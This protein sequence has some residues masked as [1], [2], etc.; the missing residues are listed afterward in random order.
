MNKEITLSQISRVNTYEGYL[1]MSDSPDPVTQLD[2]IREKLETINDSSNP[3]IVEGQLYCDD[4]HTSYSI[5]Y[6]DGKHHVVMYDLSKAGETYGEKSFVP[7]RI[8][9]VSKI[10]FRQYWEEAE[11]SFCEGMEVLIPGAYVFVGFDKKEEE[12]P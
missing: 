4:S 3:F 1:W 2:K 5:K 10:H 12:K 9:G 11:D 6:T 8:N 7:N